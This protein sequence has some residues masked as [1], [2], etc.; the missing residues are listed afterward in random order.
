VNDLFIKQ[1]DTQ[2][3]DYPLFIVMP[4]K[5]DQPG[6]FYVMKIRKRGQLKYAGQHGR[7]SIAGFFV[8]CITS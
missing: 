4:Q 1:E 5:H 6:G 3:N 7:R 2:L 8:T